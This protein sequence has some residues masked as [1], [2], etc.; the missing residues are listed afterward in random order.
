MTRR[1]SLRTGVATA[2]LTAA[3][4]TPAWAHAVTTGMGPFYDGVAHLLLTP[5]DAVILVA[6][7]LYAGLRG[8]AA[9][10]AAMFLLPTAWLLA[11]LIGSAAGPPL[12]AP[13][14][15]LTFLVAGALVAAD[16]RLSFRGVVA[17][18]IAVGLLHGY[19]NGVAFRGPGSTVEKIGRAHV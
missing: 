16:A 6:V 1:M 10:R 9:G 15:A 7:A 11:G 3:W 14:P 12:P 17:L 8:A 13:V 5:E 4:A 2:T 19:A 18:V